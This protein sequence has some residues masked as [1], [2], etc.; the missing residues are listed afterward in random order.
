MI[1]IGKIMKSKIIIIGI[2]N[3]FNYR[4]VNK[5]S[6]V[7]TVTIVAVYQIKFSRSHGGHDGVPDTK[8]TLFPPNFWVF[9]K[10]SSENCLESRLRFRGGRSE[11]CYLMSPLNQFFSKP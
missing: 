11:K 10:R 4:R 3:C 9:T 1:W 2:V 6:N 7:G 5:W 8:K